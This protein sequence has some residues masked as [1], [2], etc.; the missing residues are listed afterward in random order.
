LTD[1]I[2]KVPFIPGRVGQLGLF[3]ESGVTTTTVMIEERQGSLNLI[4]T[5]AR[6]APAV[7][8]NVNKRK[9][10]SLVVPHIALEDTI[11]A[12][13]IQNLRAFGSE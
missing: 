8:N 1:A 7:Q 5:T 11:M 2:N 6:G 4:E 12:D 10:R 9:A 3:T 13:E